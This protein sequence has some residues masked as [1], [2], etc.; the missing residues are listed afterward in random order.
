[1]ITRQTS[2][3]VT[4]QILFNPTLHQSIGCIIP[5]NLG[6]NVDGRMIVR[7]GTPLMVDLGNRQ[8]NALIANASNPMNGVLVHDVDVTDGASNGTAVI[9]GFINLARVHE[10]TLPLIT[11]AR[12]NADA[13]KLLTFIT[14]E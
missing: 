6:T 7:A 9:F 10:D 13:S 1:M 2:D 14:Q 5:T 11:T 12:G 8:A 4:R 3:T